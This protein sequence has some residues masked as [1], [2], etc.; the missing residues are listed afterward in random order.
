VS[1]EAFMVVVVVVV[2]VVIMIMF[3]VKVFWVVTP[4]NVVV[5][6]QHFRG[7][8]FIAMAPQPR[9]PRLET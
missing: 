9:R 2:V 6:Y 7:P 8:C 4:C 3:Q 5:G 1:F